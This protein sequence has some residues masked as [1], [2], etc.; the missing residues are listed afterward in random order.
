MARRTARAPHR[1]RRQRRRQRRQRRLLLPPL[2]TSLPEKLLGSRFRTINEALYTTSGAD[3]LAETTQEAERMAAYHAGFRAQTKSWPLV[4]VQ[5]IARIL[6]SS[7]SGA[8]GGRGMSAQQPLVLDLGAGEAPLARILAREEPARWKVLSFDL[9]NSADGWVRRVNCAG[10]LPLPGV[11]PW[12]DETPAL[13]MQI[14]DV[15]VFCL[16]LMG[17]DWVRMISEAQRVLRTGGDLLI[18]EVSSRHDSID[19]FVEV[20]CALGFENLTQDSSNTHFSLF[21]FRKTA[22]DRGRVARL[23]AGDDEGEAQLESLIAMGPQVLKPCLY[24]RR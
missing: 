13:E 1:R 7:A 17:T 20:I 9:D 23:V 8:Q 4:P 2:H 5:A 11:S 6:L 18:S 19:A 10:E 12:Q 15:V 22:L 24:K 14:V 16:A 21:H 3:A